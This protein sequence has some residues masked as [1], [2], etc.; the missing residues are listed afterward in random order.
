MKEPD[1]SS[2]QGHPTD[3]GVDQVGD[4][5]AVI[6]GAGL[7]GLYMLHRRG[8]QPVIFPSA[9]IALL[10]S[11]AQLWVQPAH[12]PRWIIPLNCLLQALVYILT[13]A[14]W[15]RWQAQLESVRLEDGSLNPAY[16]RLLRTHWLRVLLLSIS[17][18]LGS[19]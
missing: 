6:V 3:G 13:G 9:G 12:V 16:Q 19:D 18:K 4:V 2:R 5:D 17:A 8:V 15:G 11:F 14:W 7:A 1:M 10:G